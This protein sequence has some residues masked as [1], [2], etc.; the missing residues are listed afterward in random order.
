LNGD[1]VDIACAAAA[2]QAV[3]R[4][5]VRPYLQPPRCAEGE[6]RPTGAWRIA[7]FRKIF[8]RVVS[9]IRH[10]DADHL[11]RRPQKASCGSNLSK[12]AKLLGISRPTLY[13]M[14]HQHRISLD[15]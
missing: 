3:A 10:Y 8:E 5:T 6:S 2:L 15:A 12:A 7:L 11:T 1:L 13:D 14:M 4:A 9:G